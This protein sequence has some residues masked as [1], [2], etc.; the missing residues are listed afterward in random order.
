MW[1]KLKGRGDYATLVP[2]GMVLHNFVSDQNFQTGGRVACCMVFVPCSSADAQAW[3]VANTDQAP[4]H[5]PE[6]DVA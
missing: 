6:E 2:G 1:T 5:E 4:A 3:V